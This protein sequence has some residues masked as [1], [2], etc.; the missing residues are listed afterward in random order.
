MK[1]YGCKSEIIQ[2]GASLLDEDY[3]IIDE[4]NSYVHPRYG[5]LDPFIHSLT[6]IEDKNISSAPSL[7]AVLLNF[8]QWLPDEVCT[9]VSWSRTDADQLMKELNLK[10]ISFPDGQEILDHWIDAQLMF[11][12]KVRSR[13]AYKL[14]EALF[15]AGV[16]SAGHAHDGLS[17][18]HN[19]ALLFAL[20]MKNE[21]KISAIYDKANS[22]KTTLSY[23][24][25]DLFSN[26]CLA[27]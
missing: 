5:V 14:S 13:S 22:E 9:F 6:G 17:D 23:S 15:M 27:S 11:S 1:K 8:R 10:N 7:E 18:A 25:G 16:E 2:I 12:N 26:I 3:Q 20:M 24:L 21:M 19:T 4:F